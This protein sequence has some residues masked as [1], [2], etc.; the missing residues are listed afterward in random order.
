MKRVVGIVLCS[1]VASIAFGQS[2]SQLKTVVPPSPNAASLGKYGDIPV[3]YHT[4]VPNI[5]IPLYELKEGDVNL[6]VSLSY[7]ASGVRVAEVASWVGLGWSL[8]A[9][10]V[11][12][13]FGSACSR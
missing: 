9:G 10:G 12:T 5:S 8:N 1:I 7:H 2:S 3:G 11:I 4:G 6:P 13:R